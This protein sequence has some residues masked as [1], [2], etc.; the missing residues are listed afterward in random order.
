MVLV[1]ARKR[2]S[3]IPTHVFRAGY[4]YLTDNEGRETRE[5]KRERESE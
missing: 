4:V 1:E 2:E 5:E 3:M